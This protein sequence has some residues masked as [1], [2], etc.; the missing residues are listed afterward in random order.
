MSHDPESTAKKTQPAKKHHARSTTDSKSNKQ[1]AKRANGRR[2]ATSQTWNRT[3]T[4]R[5][6]KSREKKMTEKGSET[7]ARSSVQTPASKEDAKMPRLREAER[8]ARQRAPRKPRQIVPAT[9][10]KWSQDSDQKA[11]KTSNRTERRA[12]T[13]EGEKSTPNNQRTNK[14]PTATETKK[15]L[16]NTRKT[17]PH[18]RNLPILNTKKGHSTGTTTQQ[19]EKNRTPKRQGE[20][21]NGNKTAREWRPKSAPYTARAKGEHA[22]ANR[23]TNATRKTTKCKKR[24]KPERPK[25]GPPKSTQTQG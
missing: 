6:S 25:H 2:K 15:G 19:H 21:S 3:K 20:P 10:P 17:K 1:A 9:H 11:Q 14:N 8:R 18:H 23:Q 4:K 22:D 13:P 7:V 16:P 12:A 5:G 24:N